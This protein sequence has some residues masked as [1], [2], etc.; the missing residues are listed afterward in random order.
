MATHERPPPRTLSDDEDEQEQT[1]RRQETMKR[2]LPTTLVVL[3]AVG[4]SFAAGAERMKTAVLPVVV[5]PEDVPKM[6]HPGEYVQEQMIVGMRKVERFDVLGA[7]DV[8][9][10]LEEHLFKREDI[11]PGN[12]AELAKALGVRLL[13]FGTVKTLTLEVETIDRVVIQTKE[14][15]CEASVGATLYDAATAKSV[16]MGPYPAQERKLGAEDPRKR[17][18]IT[19]EVTE[20]MMKRVLATSAKY[21]RARVY[22]LYPLVGKI[23]RV[24]GDVVVLDI[25][26]KMGVAVGHKYTVYG[27]VEREDPI[28]GLMRRARDEISLLQV[29]EVTEESA[30]CRVTRGEK[31]PPV[32]STVERNLKR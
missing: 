13:V 14:A 1:V 17:F 31:N 26:T 2:A 32:G 16:A 23:S 7:G 9:L 4:V 25:G 10:I 12:A 27:M 15:V 20:Q 24:E 6:F 30:R 11:K 18:T 29:D 5:E 22:K 3:L 8:D 19:D 28:T 21:V